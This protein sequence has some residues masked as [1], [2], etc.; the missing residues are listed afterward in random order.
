M[1]V[2]AL[3]KRKWWLFSLVALIAVIIG[4]VIMTANRSTAEMTFAT[5]QRGTIEATVDVP[6]EVDA[7]VKARLKFLGGGKIV[8]LPVKEGDTVYR[9]NRIA[10]IDA[11]DLQKSL[12]SSL[13]DYLTTRSEFDQGIEDR[14]DTALTNALKRAADQSQYGL[15]KSVLAVELK[16]IAL[17]NAT[18]TSPID[19]IVV[20]LPV[21]TVGVPVIAT[22][23]FEI[24]NPATLIFTAEVDEVD[25]ASVKVGTK[26]RIVLDAYPDE[27]IDGAIDW[28]GLRAQV[29]SQS[30]GGTIFPVRVRLP[31]VDLFKFRLGMNGTMT[32]VL[33]QKESVLTIPIEAA[34]VKD[35]KNYVQ[36]KDSNNPSKTIEREIQT[37]IENEDT[38]EVSAGLAEGDEVLVTK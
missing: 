25:I 26:V 30:S 18:L 11:R 15:N 10:S 32:I 9:G 24:V 13:Q 4:Y 14:K 19:G 6:G 3:F 37:G 5:V 17:K 34:T 16:D 36:L 23:V 8:S 29:S 22:D 7:Q 33:E 35:G 1:S 28:V 12:E 2:I 21:E 38:I 20:S 31:S 27:T